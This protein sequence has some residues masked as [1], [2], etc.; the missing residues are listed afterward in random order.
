MESGRGLPEFPGVTR[1]MIDESDL[2][3]VE[4]TPERQQWLFDQVVEVSALTPAEREDDKN[5]DKAALVMSECWRH[6]DDAGREQ[7]MALCEQ[8]PDFK[9]TMHP[10]I[11]FD[12]V[13]GV[14]PVVFLLEGHKRQVESGPENTG[15]MTDFYEK[16]DHLLPGK[17][18]GER[19]WE[20]LGWLGGKI[21]HGIIDPAD[22]AKKKIVEASEKARETADKT[23]IAIQWVA[24]AV[25]VTGLGFIAYKTIGQDRSTIVVTD[26]G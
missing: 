16:D 8:H 21:Q 3:E 17:T 18:S 20:S 26:R 25:I 19:L 24:G 11:P 15:G 6:S 5:K 14:M 1:D 7:F 9:T 4:F 13:D 22:E 10:Y 2:R 12:Y 23:R